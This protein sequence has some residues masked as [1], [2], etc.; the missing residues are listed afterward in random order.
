[1]NDKAADPSGLFNEVLRNYRNQK[2]ARL[3]KE[4]ELSNE[5]LSA[6]LS[7]MLSSSLNKR[8]PGCMD[9]RTTELDLPTS[10]TLN[11][12]GDLQAPAGKAEGDRGKDPDKAPL[13]NA[14]HR[15]F[16][17]NPLSQALLAII[18]IA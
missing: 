11:C 3:K 4:A 13:T 5:R 10:T 17:V 9:V 12:L 14:C 15:I 18:L 2:E 16:T 8:V 1:M 7:G 6:I